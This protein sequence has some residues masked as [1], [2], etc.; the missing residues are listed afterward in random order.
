MSARAALAFR[1]PRLTTMGSHVARGP[2]AVY[3]AAHLRRRWLALASR[4]LAH[5][6]VIGLRE[7]LPTFDAYCN[8]MRPLEQPG[9]QH[10]CSVILGHTGSLRLPSPIAP[11]SLS[12]E[13]RG[14]ALGV[15][16]AMSPGGHWQWQQLEERV[17]TGL[18]DAAPLDSDEVL[19]LAA[20]LS[21]EH[22]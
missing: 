9:A 13:Y 4:L 16:P 14:R 8:F 15:V 22:E 19:A 12:I 11:V 17:L 6:Y 21:D 5:A 1:L 2:L 7:A 3:E 18:A 10:V 20:S